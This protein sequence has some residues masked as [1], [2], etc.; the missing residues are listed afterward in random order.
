M[1]GDSGGKLSPRQRALQD[2]LPLIPAIVPHWQSWQG[3]AFSNPSLRH[4]D[5]PGMAGAMIYIV[6]EELIP[7]SQ[8]KRNRHEATL[9][10]MA[11]FAVMMELG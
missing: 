9:G 2:T 10:A 3:I 8:R 1:G 4:R 11:G 5:R 7:E 6:D